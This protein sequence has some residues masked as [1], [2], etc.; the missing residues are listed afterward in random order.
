[1]DNINHQP[2]PLYMSY[3]LTCMRVILQQF[4]QDKVPLQAMRDWKNFML[5]SLGLHNGVFFP[6]IVLPLLVYFQSN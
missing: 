4:M 6:L 2:P 3:I 5:N 1:M